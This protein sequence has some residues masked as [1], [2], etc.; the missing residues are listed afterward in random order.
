MTSTQKREAQHLYGAASMRPCLSDWQ[1]FSI[2]WSQE[3][4]NRGGSQP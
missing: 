3:E 2:F 1:D 4:L